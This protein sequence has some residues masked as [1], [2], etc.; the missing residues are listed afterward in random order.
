MTRSL[1]FFLG[2]ANANDAAENDLRALGAHLNRRILQQCLAVQRV[3][4]LAA[5]VARLGGRLPQR[6]GVQVQRITAPAGTVAALAPFA[7]GCDLARLSAEAAADGVVAMEQSSVGTDPHV[8]SGVVGT[9]ALQMAV[10][11]GARVTVLDKNVDRLRQL[12]LIFGNR[13]ATH[14]SNAHSIEEAV[15]SADLVVGGVLMA[16]TPASP[17]FEATSI[18]PNTSGDS[19]GGAPT[20]KDHDQLV[21]RHGALRVGRQNPG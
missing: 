4:D 18:K 14:Y 6:E 13:I 8:S 19:G 5:Q 7:T 16:Q 3:L 2:A 9:N 12:D 10:G 11:V 17:A 1:A 20:F 21:P 15:L